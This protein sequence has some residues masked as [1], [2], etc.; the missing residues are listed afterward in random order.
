MIEALNHDPK[1]LMM[2][3]EPRITVKELES[4]SVPVLLLA[5]EQDM[6]RESHTRYLA[7]KIKGSR[8]RILP[9]EGHGSYIVHSRK[10]YYFMKKFLK[11]PLP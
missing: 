8:L 1:L 7:S 9:G 11:R 6:I 5:G 10:L 4:I 3:R 2:L